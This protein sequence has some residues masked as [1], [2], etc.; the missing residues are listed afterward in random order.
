MKCCHVCLVILVISGLASHETLANVDGGASPLHRFDAFHKAQSSFSIGVETVFSNV[1]YEPHQASGGFA[2]VDKEPRYQSGRLGLTWSPADQLLVDFS[3]ATRTIVSKRDQYSLDSYQLSMRYKLPRIK[4]PWKL[5]LGA[6]IGSNQANNLTKTSFTNYDEYLV[7]RAN[8]NQPSDQ[9]LQANLIAMRPL[10]AGINAVAYLGVGQAV[11]ENQGFDGVVQDRDNCR[12]D[13]SVT[14]KSSAVQLIEPCGSVQSYRQE[15]QSRS[16]FE[17][18]YNFD[19]SDDVSGR[20]RYWQAGAQLSRR[21]GK[22]QYG[23]GYHYQQFYRGAIDLRLAE[24]G[25]EPLYSN[26]SFSGWW[27]HKVS[28]RWQLEAG[29]QYSLHPMLNRLFVLYTG[30]TSERFRQDAFLFGLDL[31]Y[32]FGL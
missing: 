20:T 30:F 17:Q 1:D 26:H 15:F 9:Q 7:T 24:R 32:R 16:A 18:E 22:G 28:T 25:G 31:R 27:H 23:I 2:P 12:Y 6:S 11:S 4:G 14:D 10:V 3:W 8:L 5:A 29:V 19:T 13:I 21:H